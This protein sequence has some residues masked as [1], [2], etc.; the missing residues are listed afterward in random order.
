M[1]WSRP[2]AASSPRRP[3]D[4][5]QLQ[6]S[7]RH[8]LQRTLCRSVHRS[9][10]FQL[11]AMFTVFVPPVQVECTDSAHH[12][13]WHGRRA[14]HD[15]PCPPCAQ[16]N[17]WA[18]RSWHREVSISGLE[19]LAGMH[20]SS[21]PTSTFDTSTALEAWR[22]VLSGSHIDNRFVFVVAGELQLHSEAARDL[23][24]AEP[25]PVDGFAYFPPGDTHRYSC[26]TAWSFQGIPQ[27]ICHGFAGGLPWL[28]I[29]ALAG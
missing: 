13:P 15:V 12:I 9:T 3:Q 5:G 6:S 27:Q 10:C 23:V 19:L 25:L 1:R 24:T 7:A 29:A 2:R 28:C 26:W 14:L 16:R 11:P 8:T 18:A 21:V 4:G 17:G 22:A 20:P